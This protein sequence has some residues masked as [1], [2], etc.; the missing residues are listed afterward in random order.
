MAH[1]FLQVL[2]EELSLRIFEKLDDRFGLLRE[3]HPSW[4]KFID[5]FFQKNKQSLIHIFLETK[6]LFDIN[7]RYPSVRINDKSIIQSLKNDSYDKQNIASWLFSDRSV[8]LLNWPICPVSLDVIE[9]AALLGKI[10]V[11]RAWYNFHQLHLNELPQHFFTS[12]EFRQLLST[13]CFQSHPDS[14]NWFKSDRHFWFF[15]TQESQKMFNDEG[16][17]DLHQMSPKFNYL[18][19]IIHNFYLN[20]HRETFV[21]F[22][23]MFPQLIEKSLPVPLSLD[24]IKSLYDFGAISSFNVENVLNHLHRYFF[25]S[26]DVNFTLNPFIHDQLTPFHQ[27]IKDRNIHHFESQLSQF[28]IFVHTVAKDTTTKD[29][30]KL[31]QKTFNHYTSNLYVTL[32]VQCWTEGFMYVDKNFTP[33][34]RLIESVL[35]LLQCRFNFW[36]K[37]NHM[38]YKDV[39]IF[40]WGLIDFVTNIATKIKFF[41]LFLEQLMMNDDPYFLIHFLSHPCCLNQKD[42]LLISLGSMHLCTKFIHLNHRSVY[43]F[44]SP[45]SKYRCT[46]QP[47]ARH[48]LFNQS[49][50]VVKSNKHIDQFLGCINE[51]HKRGCFSLTDDSKSAFFDLFHNLR[52]F[53]LLHPFDQFD[54]IPISSIIDLFCCNFTNVFFAQKSCIHQVIH[55][56]ISPTFASN[57]IR[58]V[59]HLTKNEP[60]PDP[61]FFCR[62]E[63]FELY[64]L[65][66]DPSLF[67]IFPKINKKAARFTISLQLINVVIKHRDGGTE[68]WNDDEIDAFYYSLYYSS[69]RSINHKDS[70]YFWL[71]QSDSR[72][73]RSQQAVQDLINFLIVIN[74]LCDIPKFVTQNNHN[75]F[76]DGFSFSF[77]GLHQRWLIDSLVDKK[78]ILNK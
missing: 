15:F 39:S 70:I 5:A 2:P 18:I 4:M 12:F 65:A 29:C 20:F 56:P 66:N 17:N 48:F 37:C 51:M 44:F 27:S 58:I 33:F 26:T 30:H 77:K 34:S 40:I 72:K 38:S 43:K 16:I 13:F 69:E 55:P 23:S 46:V 22:L 75:L 14:F 28:R 32:I 42:Q 53:F 1:N 25:G 78:F 24:Q 74:R 57:I 19:P 8:D 67:T 73:P 59:N 11:I 7:H 64:G 54:S 62:Y 49:I 6:S 76:N 68:M 3:V 31:I 71:M 10:D 52:H 60:H 41:A 9:H 36:F 61:K 47:F 21:N 35:F 63:T 45:E 50:M